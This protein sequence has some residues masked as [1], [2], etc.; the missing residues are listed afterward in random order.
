MHCMQRDLATRKLS[1]RPSVRL[2]VKRVICDK[3]KGTCAYIFI[4][5]DDMKEH[6]P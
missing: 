6:L 4:P 5:Y 2:S 1:V 3:T